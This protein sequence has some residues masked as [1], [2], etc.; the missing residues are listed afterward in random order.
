M[1][2]LYLATGLFDKGGISRYCRYQITALRRLFGERNVVALSLLG[3][4]PTGFETPF[5]VDWHGRGGGP[6]DKVTMSSKAL[7]TATCFRPDV[8]HAGHVNLAPLAVLAARLGGAAPV[9]N[10][11]GLEVWSHLR[12]YRRKAM[13]RVDLVVADCRFTS[14][15][16]FANRLH[17][18]RPEVIWDC[19]DLE[20]FTPG[21]CPPETLRRYGLPDKNEHFV[22]LT[23]GRLD[24]RAAHK[25]YDRLIRVFASAASE[26]LRMRLVI[27]GRGDDV[28][29]LRALAGELG[30][31]DRVTFPGSIHEADLA[32]VYRAASIFTLVSD[33][34]PG[35]GEGLPLTAL[36]AMAC[37][38]P[39]IVGNQDGSSEAVSSGDGEV[40]N[41]FVVD[42][43]DLSSHGAV[44]L[45]L[46]RD[47]ELVRKMG[48]AGRRAAE[49]LFSYERFVREHA[50]LYADL[51]RWRV[52]APAA[53]RQV[54]MAP[55]S[56]RLPITESGVP[57]SLASASVR[58]ASNGP[59]SGDLPME[60]GFL[61]GLVTEIA[62]HV[63]RD[64]LLI[65]GWKVIR[66]AIGKSGSN[67]RQDEF[68][69]KRGIYT[70]RHVPVWRL[71]L[72]REARV[73]AG[74]YGPIDP[75]LLVDILKAVDPDPHSHVFLDLGCGKGRALII[76]AEFGYRRVVG[77]ELSRKLAAVARWNVKR[78]GWK[79]IEV[80]AG[81]AAD[82]AFD[83]PNL[84]L[85]MYN[86]FGED[87]MRRVAEN[88]MSGPCP[89]IT[90][91]YVNPRNPGPLED[92]GMYETV[93]EASDFKVWRLRRDRVSG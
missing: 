72:P 84:V 1:R 35:R 4:D 80:I 85:F 19:V 20:R 58:A 17:R 89:P 76:A 77:V 88:I 15:Y 11:Y 37:G 28:G 60:T 74:R 22:I 39:I 32:D 31:A 90:I 43:F 36:E 92:L 49:R 68:D 48:A 91:I 25:G 46:A 70:N 18:T 44:I 8:V 40:A 73:T 47:P 7:A 82:F 30:V 13:G 42:P 10:V 14:E 38:L 86:P 29:R 23:L 54:L 33:R 50:A 81:N 9:L 61:R 27:A 21:V 71:G 59:G 79:N 3:P 57:G 93:A 87:V 56:L 34:G 6:A 24:R 55:R 65:T 12:W 75:G 67:P 16:V 53:Q 69:R 64:G 5:A 66:Y 45:R 41:G 26:I 2:I 62:G 78:T 63:R 52:R 83:I 51:P